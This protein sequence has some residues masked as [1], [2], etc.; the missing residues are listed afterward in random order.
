M[1]DYDA[2]A[3]TEQTQQLVGGAL[4]VLILLLDSSLL[5]C[6][7]DAVATQGDDKSLGSVLRHCLFFLGDLLW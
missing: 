2:A 6:P 5:P 3:T 4:Q 1:S 7:E